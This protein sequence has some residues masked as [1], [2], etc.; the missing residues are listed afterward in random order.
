MKKKYVRKS[1]RRY[2]KRR[3]SK[4][5]YSKRRYSKRRNRV[6]RVSRRKLKTRS[7]KSKKKSSRAGSSPLD[8]KVEKV[9][10]KSLTGEDTDKLQEGSP[11]SNRVY[12][13]DPIQIFRI[14]YS[15]SGV[16]DKIPI[17]SQ[18]EFNVYIDIEEKDKLFI[19]WINEENSTP[20]QISVPI[21]KKI[22]QEGQ[23]II[24][25][26][27]SGDGE[28]SLNALE[29]K[30]KAKEEEQLSKFKDFEFPKGEKPEFFINRR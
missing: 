21:I 23:N 22:K 29:I 3:Y 6:S 24:F 28:N 13:T 18:K 7:K 14:D 19:V 15:R 16:Y 11:E 27:Y 10:G 8:E 9:S 12:L 20:I 26:I 30:V 5:R 4:R 1:K 25:R 2:S 17:K